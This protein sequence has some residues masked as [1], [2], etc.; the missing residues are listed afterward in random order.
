MLC[1]HWVP[2]FQWSFGFTEKCD[3]LRLEKVC[4]NQSTRAYFKERAYIKIIIK[5]RARSYYYRGNTVH[6][7]V[8]S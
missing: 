3:W 6:T 1:S 5:N 2:K 4:C 8:T 7:T